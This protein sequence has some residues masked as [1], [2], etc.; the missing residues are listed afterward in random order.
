M[1][2]DFSISN[3]PVTCGLLA[4]DAQAAGIDLTLSKVLVYLTYDQW[5]SICYL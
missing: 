3:N 4:L 2:S 5:A 1:R